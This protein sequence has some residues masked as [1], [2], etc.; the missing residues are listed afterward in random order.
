MKKEKIEN[1]I[2]NG[3]NQAESAWNNVGF[4][5]NK[6]I[7]AADSV[8]EKYEEPSKIPGH[9]FVKNG[10]YK[11]DEFVALV[12]DMRN[13]SQHLKTHISSKLE[14]GFQRVFYETSALLPAIEVACSVEGGAVTEYLGDGALILFSVNINERE[15]SIQAAYRAAKNCI[16]DA[17]EIINR[18]LFKRYDLPNISL[19]AGISLS[20]ALVTLVGSDNNFQAKVI[21]ECVWEASK[22]SVGVNKIY[23]SKYLYDI[24]P[25]SKGGS[26]KFK[27]DDIGYCVIK[28]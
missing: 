8:M 4:N 13:S 5:F 14:N 12:V 27:S 2:I 15:K 21:G 7:A 1:A 19:G 24:W 26:L 6:R 10:I 25:N 23:V 17:R 28:S 3:L 11:V 9:P 22:L 20:K 16:E 18:E